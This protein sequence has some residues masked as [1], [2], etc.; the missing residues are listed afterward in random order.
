MIR[1]HPRKLQPNFPLRIHQN[2]LN[3]HTEESKAGFLKFCNHGTQVFLLPRVNL[4]FLLCFPICLVV[5]N[6]SGTHWTRERGLGAGL[7]G[8]SLNEGTVEAAGRGGWEGLWRLHFQDLQ[9]FMNH[10]CLFKAVTSTFPFD[11]L[12]FVFS[13]VYKGSDCIYSQ[14]EFT[15]PSMK[16]PL[17]FPH[18]KD[19]KSSSS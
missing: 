11:F 10:Y 18:F 9:V 16:L 17:F 8:R 1:S 19:R 14:C 4:Q 5:L 2:P 7:E 15:F 6:Y 13:Y 3:S 12:R